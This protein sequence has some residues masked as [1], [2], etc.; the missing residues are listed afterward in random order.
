VTKYATRD[1]QNVLSVT[2]LQFSH[3]M[4]STAG[5]WDNSSMAKGLW[6]LLA[7]IAATGLTH[8]LCGQAHLVDLKITSQG[9]FLLGLQVPITFKTIGMPNG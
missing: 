8:I 9:G 5:A 6:L 3:K 2:Q 1:A 4:A 7:A